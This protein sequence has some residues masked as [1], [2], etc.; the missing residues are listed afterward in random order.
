MYD[1]NGVNAYN[2]LVLHKDNTVE[3]YNLKG[4]KPE[5]WKGISPG[6]KIKSLPERLV[7]GE[8][9]FWIVRTSMQVLIYPFYG[10][11][12]LNSFKGDSMFLPDAEVKVKNSTTVEAACYDGKVRA[13]K[14]K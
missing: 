14:V 12:P 8:N 13:V 9:T 7:V 2:V 1:F 10:G 5:S 11:E 6:E 3:M 4:K